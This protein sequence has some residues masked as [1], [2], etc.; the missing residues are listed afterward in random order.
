M[1]DMCEL[2]ILLGQLWRW[3][4]GMVFH[5]LFPRQ[6]NPMLKKKKKTVSTV[7]A[8]KTTFSASRENVENNISLH[9]AATA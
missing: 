6:G 7:G 3:S 9:Y 2:P 1:S 5:S 8:D 4:C